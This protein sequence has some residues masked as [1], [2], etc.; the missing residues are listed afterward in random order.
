MFNMFK[1]QMDT[2]HLKRSLLTLTQSKESPKCCKVILDLQ[3]DP[4]VFFLQDFLDIN[5]L[6]AG[7]IAAITT[8]AAAIAP[9]GPWRS[10]ARGLP[11]RPFLEDTQGSTAGRKIVEFPRL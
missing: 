1:T 9:Y 11:L 4:H 8:G 10:G 2:L 6:C 5:A 7:S 3:I